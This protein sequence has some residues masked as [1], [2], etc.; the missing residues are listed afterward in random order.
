MA[1]DCV[2]NKVCVK[3]QNIFKEK[4]QSSSI[5]DGAEYP[6]GKVL[7]QTVIRMTVVLSMILLEKIKC[8]LAFSST[9][10]ATSPYSFKEFFVLSI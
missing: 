3:Q 1:G 9:Q 2:K 4:S 10:K 7:N 6:N 8:G 5:E